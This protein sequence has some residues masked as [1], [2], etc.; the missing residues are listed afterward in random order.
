MAVTSQLPLGGNF[1]AYGVHRED[2]PST[3]PEKDPSAQRFAVSHQYLAAMAIPVLRGRGFTAADRAGADPVV[4]LNRTGAARIF[5]ADDPLGKRIKLGGMQG[6]WRTVVGIVEDAK[7]LGLDTPP[8]EGIY[9]RWKDLPA[10]VG[11]TL[12]APDDIQRSADGELVLI[13]DEGVERTTDGD[14][15]L[16]P[17]LAQLEPASR[18]VRDTRISER[19][20]HAEMLR[21]LAGRVL[22]ESERLERTVGRVSAGNGGG[23]QDRD[24]AAD[25]AFHETD[26]AARLVARRRARRWEWVCGED[27]PEGS[28][29]QA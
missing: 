27:A 4:L 9:V 17:P 12:E 20:V 22:H 29:R 14:E 21:R 5:G 26:S 24:D 13:H 7:Y 6:P 2:R 23:E 11:L 19:L 28:R 15:L 10:S 3:S 25:R 8:S 18:V 16:S 1:D